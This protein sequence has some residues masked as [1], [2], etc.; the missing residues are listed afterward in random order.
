MAICMMM[1]S[2]CVT[3]TEPEDAEK[4]LDQTVAEEAAKLPIQISNGLTI[5]RMYL[6]DNNLVCICAVD[7]DLYNISDLENNKDALRQS[8][9]Q[10]VQRPESKLLMCCL[11]ATD[12]GLRFIYRGNKSKTDVNIEFSVKDLKKLV[13]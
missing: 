11:M 6:S 2:L 12:K 13:K 7:E 9:E 4:I 5:D 1:A 10:M 8:L 3:A